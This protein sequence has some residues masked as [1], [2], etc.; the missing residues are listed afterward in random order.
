MAAGD[1]HTLATGPSTNNLSRSLADQENVATPPN[2][3]S[4]GLPHDDSD[5]EVSNLLSTSQRLPTSHQLATQCGVQ[6]ANVQRM[7]ASFLADDHDDSDMLGEKPVSHFSP[8]TRAKSQSA[9]STSLSHHCRLGII[10]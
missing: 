2:A 1:T 5:L 10:M 4:L 8:A 3:K 7:K 6:A 9:L